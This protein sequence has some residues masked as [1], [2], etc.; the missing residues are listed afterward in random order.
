MI[1]YTCQNC[2]VKF[3]NYKS[4]N[5]KYCSKECKDVGLSIDHSHKCSLCG[6]DFLTKR[7]NSGRELDTKEQVHH[8]NGNHQDNRIENLIVV[9][10]EWHTKLHH[11]LRVKNG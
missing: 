7:K 5:S 6:K 3:M 11:M 2:S 9:T 10:P 4:D 1:E 8:I